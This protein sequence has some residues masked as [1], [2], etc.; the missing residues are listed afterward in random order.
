MPV[1]RKSGARERSSGHELWFSGSTGQAVQR[2]R[3]GPPFGTF[4]MNETEYRAV[5]DLEWKLFDGL[6]RNNALR[7]ANSLR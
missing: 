7:E 1:K 2:Y 6:E 4:N 3:A 5:L